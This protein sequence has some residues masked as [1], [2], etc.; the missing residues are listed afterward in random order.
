MSAV[1]F[2][3]QPDLHTLY[4]EHHGWLYRWL[5]RRLGNAPD[6]ADLA[7]DTFLRLLS[8]S[9]LPVV[10]SCGE[11][12]A[13]LRTTAHNLCINLWRRQELERAWLDT[14]AATP[15]ARYPSAERQAIILEALAEISA[16]LDALPAKAAQAF[17]MAVAGQMTDAEVGTRLGVSDRMVRKYVAKAMF[18]CLQLHARDT[19]QTLREDEAY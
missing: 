8:R 1:N 15:E 11:A 10:G 7:H 9:Q 17:L 14:L 12:R 16:M 13:Y 4:S 2:P 6:A 5:H 3:A 19:V 18:G